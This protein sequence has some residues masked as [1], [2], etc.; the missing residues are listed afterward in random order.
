MAAPPSG[1]VARGHVATPKPPFSSHL[2]SFQP[3]ACVVRSRTVIW[4]PSWQTP[5]VPTMRLAAFR[6][7]PFLVA[8]LCLA[9]SSALV[10]R[11]GWRSGAGREV[12][13]ETEFATRIRDA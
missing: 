7:V 1:R 11:A 6:A 10:Y 9:A 13:D 12:R 8:G 5:E 3:S 4:N 2:P